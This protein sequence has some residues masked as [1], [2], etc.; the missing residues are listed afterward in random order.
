MVNAT[1]RKREAPLEVVRLQVGHLVENLS[2]VETRGKKVEN[3]TDANTHPP[4]ARTA[5]ALLR[6]GGDTFE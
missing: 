6:V 3:I 4:H 1:A 5:S 2:G